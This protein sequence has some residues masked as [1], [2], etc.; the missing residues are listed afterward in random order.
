[1]TLYQNDFL[2]PETHLPSRVSVHEKKA[3]FIDL[4]LGII[5]A[6]LITC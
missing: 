5:S 2:I 1:M 6:N 4:N 3:K